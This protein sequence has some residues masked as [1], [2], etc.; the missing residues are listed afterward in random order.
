MVMRAGQIISAPYT[1]D[2]TPTLRQNSSTVT[3][4]V[5]LARAIIIGKL[6]TIWIHLAVTGTGTVGTQIDVVLPSELTAGSTFTSDFPGGAMQALDS[7]SA[8]YRGQVM[9]ETT[10]RLR[11]H[12]YSTSA[13]LGVSPSYA[14]ASG[15]NVK[16]T[17]TYQL[18]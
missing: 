15:D 3:A 13:L 16:L 7:G 18:A 2:F 10:A 8:A 12:I 9:F 14:L 4:T 11:F 5:T 1:L 17:A 6:C